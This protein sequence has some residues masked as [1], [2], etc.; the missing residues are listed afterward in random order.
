MLQKTLFN[1]VIY[2]GITAAIIG[3]V[4]GL[5]LGLLI[6]GLQTTVVLIKMNVVHNPY[7]TSDIP[8]EMFTMLG[9]SFGALVGSVSGVGSV[10]IE[11]KKKK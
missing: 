5:L 1:K 7:Y 3:I 8:L 10:F 11:E 9:M 4:A 6:W 2:K